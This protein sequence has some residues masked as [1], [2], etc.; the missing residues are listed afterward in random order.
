MK[1]FVFLTLL[2][3]VS[4]SSAKAENLVCEARE[5]TAGGHGARGTIGIDMSSLTVR[6]LESEENLLS[7]EVFCGVALPESA[8]CRLSKYSVKFTPSFRLVCVDGSLNPEKAVVGRA[9]FVHSEVTK[10]GR[11]HCQL[12]GAE[13]IV[14]K[15]VEF[16][17]CIS[18]NR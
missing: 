6:W 9:F 13:T 8:R 16:S 2:T 17:N 11:F 14:R 1:R 18:A 3:V 12:E 15:A 10:N 5:L 7:S 4:V